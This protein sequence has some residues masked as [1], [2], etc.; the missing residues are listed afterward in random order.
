M[1]GGDRDWL[2][3]TMK[4]LTGQT[5]QVAEVGRR[6][7]GRRAM[8]MGSPSRPDQPKHPER[9]DRPDKPDHFSSWPEK[10]CAKDS[11][12][13]DSGNHEFGNNTLKLIRWVHRLSMLAWAPLETF[14]L[15]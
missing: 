6:N 13:T 3:E 1:E 5:R 2:A 11:A 7:S 10:G 8:E 9:L 12:Q 14:E 15:A 4:L